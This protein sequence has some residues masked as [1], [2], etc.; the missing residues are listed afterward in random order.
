MS[1][2]WLLWPT[3]TSNTD[4]KSE[5]ICFTLWKLEQPFT[6]TVFTYIEQRQPYLMMSS[7]KY[8]DVCLGGLQRS[9]KSVMVMYGTSLLVMMD[10]KRRFL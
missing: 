1:G 9:G 6:L 8:T 4:V 7:S 5:V 3:C 10:L 2:L